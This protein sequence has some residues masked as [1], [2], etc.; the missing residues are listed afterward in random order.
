MEAILIQTPHPLLK[1]HLNYCVNLSTAEEVVN[2]T[3]VLPVKC[4][5]C[6]RNGQQRSNHTSSQC[7]LHTAGW[8]WGTWRIL[9]GQKVSACV[10]ILPGGLGRRCLS[11]DLNKG[12]AWA[13]RDLWSGTGLGQKA[14]RCWSKRQG[15]VCEVEKTLKIKWEFNQDLNMEGICPQVIRKPLNSSKMGS[16]RSRFIF[17][18]I[19]IIM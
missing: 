2:N 8:V 4:F 15:S 11:M 10:F 13:W 1:I 9:K 17:L 12:T 19:S 16:N 3:T 5:Q 18:K 7:D 14:H 6:E